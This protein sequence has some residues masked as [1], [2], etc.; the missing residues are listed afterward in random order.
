MND[1]R[2]IADWSLLPHNPQAFFE[3]GEQFDRTELKR[4]YN[5][6]LRHYKPEKFPA[7]FQRI[8]AAYEHLDN[9]LRYGLTVHPETGAQPYEWRTD[10]PQTGPQPTSPNAGYRAGPAD[11]EVQNRTAGHITLI[12]QL[13]RQPLADVYRRLADNPDKTA[14]EYYSLAVMS[15]IVDRKDGLQFA[16]WLLKGLRQHARD[17]GLTSLLYEYFCGPVPSAA[18]ASLLVAASQAVPND[19]FF[20]LTEP[21]WKQLLASRPFN[22]F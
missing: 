21:L 22:E 2:E 6:L 15:D 12:E 4:S 7:E 14:Y 5:R 19:S 18:V 20:S 8:R 9:Q 16:R 3:L 13:Q 1:G 11:A 17:L 10:A